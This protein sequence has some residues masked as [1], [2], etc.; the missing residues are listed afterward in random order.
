[1]S[2][3][4]EFSGKTA[5]VTGGAKGIGAATVRWLDSQGIGKVF[6]LDKDVEPLKD[7]DLACDV[8]AIAGD[9]ADE[10]LWQQFEQSHGKIDYA[11]LNAGIQIAAEVTDLSFADWRKVLGVNLDGAFLGLRASL[12]NMKHFGGGSVVMVASVGGIKPMKN[13]AA[14]GPAK[15]GMIHLTKNAALETAGLG[16]RVNCIAP[17]PVDTP[18]WDGNPK[19]RALIEQMG[20][21]EAA[22]A[23]LG[24]SASPMGRYATADELA[25]QIGFLLSN[26]AADITG[27]V[28]ASDCGVGLS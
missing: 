7:L 17:G 10:E 8:Q 25:G 21:R 23:E 14:Y 19:F 11:V 20:S 4:S 26:T 27:A 5:L 1:M 12:R 3:E 24:K 6:V 15:A 18:I 22:V 13:L 9:V 16:I 28:L 2:I